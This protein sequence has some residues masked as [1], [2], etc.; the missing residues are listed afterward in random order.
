MVFRNSG[1]TV[2]MSFDEHYGT[3]ALQRLPGLDVN[4]LSG[5]D[6]QL[7]TAN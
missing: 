2:T 5:T 7:R 6:I 3:R 4:I 1:S